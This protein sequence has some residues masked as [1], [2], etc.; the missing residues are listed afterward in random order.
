VAAVS[1]FADR[2]VVIPAG[3]YSGYTAT[4][5]RTITLRDRSA[6]PV[7]QIGWINGRRAVAVAA[8]ALRGY[9]LPLYPG[10]SLR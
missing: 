4:R 5:H 9:W 2:T 10:L 3:S 1:Y 6:A 7:S 8:G